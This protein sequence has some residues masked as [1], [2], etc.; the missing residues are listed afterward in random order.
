MSRTKLIEFL[1]RLGGGLGGHTK[2]SSPTLEVR[3]ERVLH[4]LAGLRCPDAQ[5]AG[6]VEPV[7]VGDERLMPSQEAVV[8]EAAAIWR[9][10]TGGPPV[11]QLLGPPAVGKVAVAGAIVGV[12]TFE[13]LTNNPARTGRLYG[14]EAIHRM[15]MLQIIDAMGST[16]LFISGG[17]G[18]FQDATGP[19]SS[20]YYGGLIMLA[21]YFQIPVCFLG[22]GLGPLNGGLSRWMTRNALERCDAVTVRDEGSAMLVQELTGREPAL[23]AD[24]VWLLNMPK[25]RP[26]GGDT[27]Q[28]GVSLRPWGQLTDE[29]LKG[30]VRTL[31]ELV[32]LRD[33]LQLVPDEHLQA[34]R[35]PFF[36]RVVPLM[37]TCASS[38]MAIQGLW[39]GP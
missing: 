35:D 6:F 37:F 20:L 14:V 25:Q 10:A 12:A 8:T 17:G 22:Q 26:Q 19:N 30:F 27:W 2:L 7:S 15:S 33:A 38:N 24:P 4:H 23:V 36:W 31:A 5:L 9:A 16:H 32:A 29:R 3:R 39:A 1:W 34:L 11:L 13:G 18:L 21:G 28:I